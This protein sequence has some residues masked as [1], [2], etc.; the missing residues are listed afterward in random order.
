MKNLILMILIMSAMFSCKANKDTANVA[1]ETP[2]VGPILIPEERIYTES[3]MTIGKRICSAL[4]NKRQLFESLSN[5]TEA[6]RF[7]GEYKSCAMTYP[8]NLTEFTATISNATTSDL[9]YVS[10]T[11]RPYDYFKDVVTDHN[12]AMK[13][14]C[15]NLAVSD[16]VS[17]YSLSGS[18]YVIVNLLISEG[19]DRFEVTKLS[20]N[21]NNNYQAVSSESVNI[22][23]QSGQTISKFFGVEKERTLYLPCPNSKE[24]SYNKQT[25]ITAVTN[26]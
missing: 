15:E 16:S 18:S 25:W 4:K 7:K 26:F 20:K 9:Q 5:Q 19:F 2:G 23:T 10:T 1:A 24:T 13:T 22:L 8:Q 6:F 14:I 11:S 17:N 3:E 21:S 12:G